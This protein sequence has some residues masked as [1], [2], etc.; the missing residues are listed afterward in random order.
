MSGSC[1]AHLFVVFCFV[2]VVV[3]LV[4]LFVCFAFYAGKKLRREEWA[5]L[6]QLSYLL[7]SFLYT[8]VW[9]DYVD[10]NCYPALAKAM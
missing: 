7:K 5:P 9:G 4:C 3:V 8:C 2:V 10:N 1:I 6:N